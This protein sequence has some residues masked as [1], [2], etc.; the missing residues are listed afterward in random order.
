[1]SQPSVSAI[2]HSPYAV[3]P[4]QI[5]RQHFHNSIKQNEQQESKG[6]HEFV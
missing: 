3:L 2:D 5:H 4:G 1:M 6:K